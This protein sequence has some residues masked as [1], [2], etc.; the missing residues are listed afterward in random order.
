MAGR[1]EGKR[2]VVTGAASG[3]GR[4]SA[5]LFAREGAQLLIA[6]W[7]EDALE[8]TVQAIRSEGG[9]ATGMR[10]DAGREE[11]VRALI[12]RAVRELGG[13]DVVFA[14]AG[15]AGNRAGLAE[16]ALEQFQEVLRVNLLG[17]FLAIKYASAEM[18]KQGKG[19]IVCTASVAGIGANA[20][21]IAYSASKA[22]VISLVQTCAHDLRGTGVRL[23]AICPGLIE[24][25]MTQ[26]MFTYARERGSQHKLGQFT[27]LERAGQPEEIA[28]AA[29]FLASDDASYV[30]GQAIPVDGGLTA[31][32]PY[33]PP[34]K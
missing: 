27:P 15:I 11:D 3:I 34:K 14:N 8:E 9:Q 31:S 16:L 17:P 12:E 29:L 30:H 26:G 25:S 1:L 21:S 22:A 4:A 20:G 33:L 13:L 32:V 23:N 5:L 19:A 28:H 2:V 24:T 10:I 6:D 18:K 7:A